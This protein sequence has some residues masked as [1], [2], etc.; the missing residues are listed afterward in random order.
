MWRQKQTKQIVN[1]CVLA[2]SLSPRLAVRCCISSTCTCW[3]A[4]I[5]GCCVRA[6]TCTRSSWWLCLQRSSIFT[7]IT[8]WAGVSLPAP[9]D[10]KSYF[11]LC[12]CFIVHLFYAIAGFDHSLK[13]HWKAI[14]QN[15]TQSSSHSLLVSTRSTYSMSARTCWQFYWTSRCLATRAILFF[16]LFKTGIIGVICRTSRREN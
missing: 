5:S 4:I 13:T 14:Q 11:Y 16:K 15:K 9:F 7:G 10:R 6:Y 12:V 2:P 8:S 1:I 3:A